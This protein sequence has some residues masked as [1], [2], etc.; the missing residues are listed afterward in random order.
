MTSFQIPATSPMHYIT[1][2]MCTHPHAYTNTAYAFSS[3]Q[4]RL[5]LTFPSSSCTLCGPTPATWPAM[6][7]K[8]LTNSSSLLSMCST[9]TL[10]VRR[11]PFSTLGT[12]A[13]SW[14]RRLEGGYSQM[15]HARTA[16]ELVTV[17]ASDAF[18]STVEP[19][20]YGHIWDHMKCPE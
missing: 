4:V 2:S 16:S 20:L 11:P 5:L 8:T 18:L 15:S 9:I 12:V 7:N 19:L 1:L 17:V 10:V 13:A 14:T 3:I 6:S